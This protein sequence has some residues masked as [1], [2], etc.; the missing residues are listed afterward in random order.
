MEVVAVG[1]KNKRMTGEKEQMD[2]KSFVEGK[3]H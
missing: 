2:L 1:R 3:D